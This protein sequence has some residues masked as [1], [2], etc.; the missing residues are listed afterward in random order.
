MNQGQVP[1]CNPDLLADLAK[2]LHLS[3]PSFPSCKMGSLDDIYLPV[4]LSRDHL[5][6]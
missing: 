4:T 2:A 3:E 5:T 6:S 1:I